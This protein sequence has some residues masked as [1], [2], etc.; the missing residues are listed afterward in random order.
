MV[1]LK[2]RFRQQFPAR[3]HNRSGKFLAE[4]FGCLQEKE[5]PRSR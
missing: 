5:L 2:R 3:D 4:A 1:T